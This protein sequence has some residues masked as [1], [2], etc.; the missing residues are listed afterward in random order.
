MAIQLPLSVLAPPSAMV[1]PVVLRAV[2]AP[3]PIELHIHTNAVHAVGNATGKVR[4]KGLSVAPEVTWPH[5]I[6]VPSGN[7]R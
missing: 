5:W 6:I 2:Y 7:F 1:A 3:Y 4:E